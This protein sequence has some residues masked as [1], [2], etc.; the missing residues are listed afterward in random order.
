M[1][2]VER[3]KAIGEIAQLLETYREKCEMAVADDHRIRK[4]R[5]V[6]LPPRGTR[7]DQYVLLQKFYSVVLKYVRASLMPSS[8]ECVKSLKES[9]KASPD[10]L[11]VMYRILRRAFRRAYGEEAREKRQRVYQWSAILKWAWMEKVAEDQFV[12]RVMEEGG[13]ERAAERWHSGNVGSG[14][15]AS[16]A[17]FQRLMNDN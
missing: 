16:V 9:G 15:L 6:P 12:M 13:M 8:D 1:Q 3:G 2:K 4:K 11:K 7:Y 14:W 10:R 17:A 5:V